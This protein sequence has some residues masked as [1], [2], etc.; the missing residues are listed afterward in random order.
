MGGSAGDPKKGR[1]KKLPTGKEIMKRRTPNDPSLRPARFEFDPK[2]A[3][4]T[5]QLAEIGAISVKWNQIE[6]HIAFVGSLILFNKAPLWLQLSTGIVLSTKAKLNLLK[7]CIRNADLLD[8][9]SKQCIADCFSQVEQCR[10]YRNAIIH[11]HI[12]DP[13]KG[14]GS[15]I[16]ESHSSYQILVSLDALKLLY[17]ILCALLEELREI[18]LLFR[19]ETGAQRPGRLDRGEFEPFDDDELRK[20][21]I[22]GH[23]KRLLA[24]QTSRKELQKRLPKFPDADLIRAITEKK[25]IPE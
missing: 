19:I 11:H 14:I 18:D 22:P 4:T 1:D 13:E 21:I 12:Y 15:Y 17:G 5:E 20:K 7:E 16:D 24:L 10:A 8:D 6:P 3:Y 9:R 2:K 23:T 25:G